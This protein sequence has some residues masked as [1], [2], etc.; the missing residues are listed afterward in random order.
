MSG[1]TRS[2]LN[3]WLK[4]T[5]SSKTI[6]HRE[7]ITVHIQINLCFTQPLSNTSQQNSVASVR[8]RVQE[9]ILPPAMPGSPKDIMFTNCKGVCRE[10]ENTNLNDLTKTTHSQLSTASDLVY[11]SCK[12]RE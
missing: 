4:L 12:C 10:Q 8:E 2:S 5:I 11:S 1:H 3:H 7:G 9:I 6:D